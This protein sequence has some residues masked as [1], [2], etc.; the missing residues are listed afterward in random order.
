M[1]TNHSYS[2]SSSSSSSSIFMI[3]ALHG[4]ATNHSYSSSSIFMIAALHGMAAAP[5]S[6]MS[7]CHGCL[8]GRPKFLFPKGVPAVKTYENGRQGHWA[9][10]GS[11]HGMGEWK[12]FQKKQHGWKPFRHWSL[13]L[14]GKK[15]P[16]AGHL[17]WRHVIKGPPP[18]HRVWDCKALF[19]DDATYSQWVQHLAPCL[20]Y[21]NGMAMVWVWVWICF[22][23]CMNYD[24]K[25][26]WWLWVVMAN[27]CMI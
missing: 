17:H 10:S 19:V 20:H 9:A 5:P 7:W 21:G 1:A 26:S 16:A 3:A 11:W 24:G 12:V 13:I 18:L 4:M 15:L 25:I 23:F 6:F 22:V 8:G 27:H 14:I 2:S